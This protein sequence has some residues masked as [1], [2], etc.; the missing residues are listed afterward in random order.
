MTKDLKRYIIKKDVW[1]ANKYMKRCSES[2]VR[3]K[4]KL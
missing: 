4:L 1:M 3:E 2:L